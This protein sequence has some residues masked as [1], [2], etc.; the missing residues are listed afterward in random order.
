MILVEILLSCYSAGCLKVIF[1]EF[2]GGAASFE[3][4]ARFCYN[5]GKVIIT[6]LNIF[7]LTFHGN[8][9]SIRPNARGS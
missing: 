7:N 1:S 9:Q 3:I 6:P 2:P 5:K 4:I 8:G